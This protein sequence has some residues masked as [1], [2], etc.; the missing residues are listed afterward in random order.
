MISKR[1][2]RTEIARLSVTM[3]GMETTMDFV[4]THKDLAAVRTEVT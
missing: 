2:I 4:A 3:A 1:P